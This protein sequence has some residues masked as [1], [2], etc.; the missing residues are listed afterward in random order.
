MSI[1]FIEPEKITIIATMKPPRAPTRIRGK[2]SG[3]EN[4]VASAVVAVIRSRI[5]VFSAVPSMV[6][7]LDS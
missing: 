5:P 7:R 4:A 2:E 3:I 6:I 1:G